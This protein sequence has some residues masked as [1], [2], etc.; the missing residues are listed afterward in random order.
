M[1]RVFNRGLNLVP[2]MGKDILTAF[3]NISFPAA[4]DVA[5][6]ALRRLTTAGCDDKFVL[7]T[8]WVYAMLQRLLEEERLSLAALPRDSEAT[9]LG[10]LRITLKQGKNHVS[11]CR[12][13]AD[14]IEQL[15]AAARVPGTSLR[16]NFDALMFYLTLPNVLR[17]YAHLAGDLTERTRPTKE[18]VAQRNRILVSLV[19]HVAE[20]TGRP[21][22]TELADVI[23]A[24]RE[25]WPF[26]KDINADVLRKQF[27]P[28]SSTNLLRHRSRSKDEVSS[29]KGVFNRGLNVVPATEKQILTALENIS[30]PATA[31]VAHSA[32]RRLTTAGCDDKFVLQ[33]T[34]MY[35]MVQRLLEEER[36]GLAALPRDSEATQLGGL[37]ITLKQGKNHVSECRRIADDME[38]YLAVA[39]VP[40]GSLRENADIFMFYLTLPNVLRKYASFVEDLI[41]R[42]RPT[43][44]AVAQRNRIVVSLVNHVTQATG[45]SFFTE[46]ADII[47]AWRE[48][49]P[50]SNDMNADVLRKQFRRAACSADLLPSFTVKK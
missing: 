3:E 30:F 1:K 48:T 42:T 10:G 31:D 43:K 7:Q 41:E 28:G 35:A 18:A 11:E 22:F 20:T 8:T 2:A 45:H 5:H 37:R 17:K 44:E 50:F 13:I 29:I 34:W 24:W 14:D 25:T 32:L 19:N 26:S 33:T 40:G 49:W 12:R 36:L 39:R 27:R 23:L 15:L 46:L 4:A 21:F 47:L 9:Q 6:S 16:D 38:R